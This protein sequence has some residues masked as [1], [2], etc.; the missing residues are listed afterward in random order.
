MNELLQ[1]C[2]FPVLKL[3]R[4]TTSTTK[5]MVYSFQVYPCLKLVLHDVNYNVAQWLSLQQELCFVPY[6]LTVGVTC[7]T[8]HHHDVITYHNGWHMYIHEH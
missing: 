1:Y 6:I 7:F 8:A 4:E 3:P 2:Q 5:S